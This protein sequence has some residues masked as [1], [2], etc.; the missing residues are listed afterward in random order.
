MAETMR[1][2]GPVHALTID[3]EDYFHAAALARFFPRE[4]WPHLERRVVAN[5]LRLLDLLAARGAKATWFVLGWVGEREPALVRRIAEAGHEIASHGYGH[6]SLFA[7]DPASFRADVARAKAVLEDATGRPVAGYR[8]PNFSLGPE[9]AWAYGVLAEVGHRYSSS[10]HPARLSAYRSA[11]AAPAPSVRDTI[12][13]IPVSVLC[14][15]VAGSAPFAG[16]AWFR[17]MPEAY[18]SFAFRRAERSGRIPV[19]FYLHPWEIDPDQPRPR[20]LDLFT[21]LRHYGG[22]ARAP[23]RLARLLAAHRFDRLDRAHPA[24]REIAA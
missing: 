22:L 23:S 2:R 6:A 1:D 21:R 20:G 7:L 3:L 19:V 10:T 5:T 14:L 11:A 4:R 16:G 8:A 9:T 24:L 12:L 17:L 18:L 15:P 13:E